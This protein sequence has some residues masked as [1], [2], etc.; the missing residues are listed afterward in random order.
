MGKRRTGEIDT[1]LKE[2]R[3]KFDPELMILFG[4][5][6]R[7]EALKSSDYDILIVSKKFDGIHFLDRIYRLLELWD[8]DWDVDLLPYTPEEFEKK[9]KEIGIVREAVKEGIEMQ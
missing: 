2:V 4:S 7:D 5:R 3:K 6:A 9:K 1:F 8:Y